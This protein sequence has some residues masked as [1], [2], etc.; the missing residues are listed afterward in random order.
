[1][2]FGPE[3]KLFGLR[4]GPLFILAECSVSEF[5]VSDTPFIFQYFPF[6]CPATGLSRRY[7]NTTKRGE[8]AI[9]PL[10]R[11]LS[12]LYQ[13]ALLTP[14]KSDKS[15]KSEIVLIGEEQRWD[16]FST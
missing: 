15:R 8:G 4:S 12:M 3:R 13:Q 5:I 10:C 16:K 11:A 2:L 7:K 6:C 9:I 14:Y 1:M